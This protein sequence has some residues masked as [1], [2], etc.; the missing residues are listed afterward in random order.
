[1]SVGVVD[2]LDFTH[3]A[4]KDFSLLLTKNHSMVKVASVV[5]M[6]CVFIA[7]HTICL[8]SN[9]DSTNNWWGR[10][11]AFTN[12]RGKRLSNRHNASSDSNVGSFLETSPVGTEDCLLSVEALF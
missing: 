9:T 10:W 3:R 7:S 2:Q 11:R 6:C 12:S 4:M 5:V 1:M 8:D